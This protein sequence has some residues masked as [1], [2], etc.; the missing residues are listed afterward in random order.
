MPSSGGQEGHNLTGVY[1][2]NAIYFPNE[3]ELNASL[4]MEEGLDAQKLLTPESLQKTTADFTELNKYVF[5][6]PAEM[7]EEALAWKNGTSLPQRTLSL[8]EQEVRYQEKKNLMNDFYAKALE[9][10]PKL[11]PIQLSHLRGN[12]FLGIFAHSY[13]KDYFVSLPESEKQII[14][15]N[16][17]WLVSLRKAA[18]DE[19][20]RRGK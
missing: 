20:V 3:E 8:N 15:T 12:S 2:P 11:S 13:L 6:S 14:D 1:D 17:H 18:I 9:D 7:D 16:L 5:L 10:I 4:A 19:A